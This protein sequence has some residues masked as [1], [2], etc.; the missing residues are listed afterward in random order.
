MNVAVNAKYYERSCAY[1]NGQYKRLQ[2]TEIT[3]L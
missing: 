1:G 3:L 2:C